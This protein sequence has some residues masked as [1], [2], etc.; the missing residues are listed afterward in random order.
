MAELDLFYDPTAPVQANQLEAEFCELLKMFEELSLER[1][2]EIGVF[3]GGSL[4]Q[5][6]KRM[7][8]GMVVALDAPGRSWGMP[9]S[10]SQEEW[11]NWGKIYGIRVFPVLADSHDPYTVS[12]VHN[13]APFDF[14]FIDG[15]HSYEGVRADWINYRHMIRKG[16]IM[17]FHDILPDPSDQGIEVWRLWQ[18]IA[19]TG[20]Y[21]TRELL[22]YEG[23]QVKGIGV[24]C[25]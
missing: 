9:H 11:L 19:G 13:F 14:M 18:E 10:D 8:K 16:G 3:V 15:D 21:E 5:W 12:I 24:I 6:I 7:K 25:F 4:Y 1:A 2:L 20:K 22:S 23:Q 17:A